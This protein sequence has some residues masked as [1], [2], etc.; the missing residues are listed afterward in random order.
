MG[1]YNDVI[2]PKL[3]HLSMRNKNLVPYRER[4]IGGAQGR[5]LEIGIG[6]GMNLPFYGS[7]VREVLALEPSAPLVDMARGAQHG[8]DFPVRFLEASAEAIPLEDRCV[9]TVVTTWTLCTIPNA[10]IALKE[11]RRVLRLGGQLLFVEHGLAPDESVRRWQH[12]LTPAWRR[13]A[14]GC[15][16]NRQISTMIEEGGFRLDRLETGYMPGPKPMTFMYEGSARPR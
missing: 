4:V 3:C 8:S 9:D 10:D 15:H 7:G 13:I 1:F 6:S 11:M 14:G 16:L 5:V 12:W 2:L